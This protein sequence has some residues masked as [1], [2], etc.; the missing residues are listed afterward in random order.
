M[1]EHDGVFNFT[2]GQCKGLGKYTNESSF[3]TA[4]D[5]ESGNICLGNYEDLYSCSLN[6]CD[7]HYT[8]RDRIITGA[9]LD[10]KIRYSAEQSEAIITEVIGDKLSLIFKKPQRAITAGQAAVF[11]KDDIMLGGGTIC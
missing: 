3:V 4:I 11:Y 8:L 6:V 9:F 1:G 10:V 2:I 5:A 7:M